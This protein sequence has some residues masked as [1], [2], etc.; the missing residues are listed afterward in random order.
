[1]NISSLHTDYL[2]VESSSGF[3]RNSERAHNVQTKCTFCG[4]TNNSAEKYF[5]SIRKDKEKA[6]AVDASDNRRT[7]QP[8]RKC[9]SCRSEDHLISKCPKPPK[10][11]EKQQKQVCLIKKGRRSCDNGKNNSDQKIYACLARMSGNDECSSENFGDSSQLTNWI[12]DYG[13]TCHMKPEVSYYITGSL[14]DTDKY[15]EVADG[16]HV[17]AKQKVQARIK[18]C[19]DNR[20]PYLNGTQR[21]FG[22]KLMRQ[23][24]L[25]HYINEFRTY[26]Y[27]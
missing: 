27:S 15:I 21:T 25:N 14:E 13:A 17:T 5:K 6:R 11:N 16:H 4:G 2:N 26:L 23:V 9:F 3:G 7:E 20:D 22:T 18:M 10:D 12:L 24:I 8:P 19:E 1:M